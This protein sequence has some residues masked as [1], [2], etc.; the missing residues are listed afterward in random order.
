[1][2]GY[3]PRAALHAADAVIDLVEPPGGGLVRQIR[4]GER[5]P[6]HGH[7]IGRP[8]GD[9]CLCQ[10]GIG[11]P[12]HGDDRNICDLLYI[13]RIAGNPPVRDGGRGRNRV[14][15]PVGPGR[16]VD[17]VDPIS[18]QDPYDSLGLFKRSPSGDQFITRYPEDHGEITP[19]LRSNIRQ[20]LQG[21]PQ[22]VQE[23][24]AVPVGSFVG[25]KGHELGDQ[26]PVGTMDLDPVKSGPLRP[27]G[28]RSERLHNL[29]DLGDR[30]GAGHLTDTRAGDRRGG[31]G[32][33]ARDTP[34][35]LAPGVVD[36]GED[37][38]PRIM[39][40]PGQ[41]R[42]TRDLAV[43][44]QARY[45]GKALSFRDHGVVFGDDQSPSPAGLCLMVGD[46]PL[47]RRSVGVAEIHHHR[48]YHQPVGDLDRSDRDRGKER[49][50]HTTSLTA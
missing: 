29:F 32:L 40:P 34:G 10:E 47:R 3:H 13:P 17:G 15:A 30:Q 5:G 44:P 27:Q 6:P 11:D 33:G 14:P 50:Y 43:V 22:P 37:N 8:A 45:I 2:A 21:K 31:H 41:L 42:V 25:M 20:D 26:I 4:I 36:L 19:H 48:R 7:Q 46:V 49:L 35:G 1:M 12:P 39:G 28:T 24:A 16:D 18:L 38:P 9:D 23:R